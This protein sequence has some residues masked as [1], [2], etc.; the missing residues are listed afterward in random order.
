MRA[1]TF[2]LKNSIEKID[3]LMCTNSNATKI[4]IT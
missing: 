3:L 1:E 2:I 4:I